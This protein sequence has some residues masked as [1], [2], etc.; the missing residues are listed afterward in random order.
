[1]KVQ[2]ENQ[3]LQPK[4]HHQIIPLKT[5]STQPLLLSLMLCNLLHSTAAAEAALAGTVLAVPAAEGRTALA[6][7]LVLVA[8]ASLGPRRRLLVG[9]GD[10][11]G[12][13]GQVRTQVLDALLGEVAVVV[14][15]REG[16]TDVSLGVERLHEVQNLKVGG[17]LDVGVG[18]R[19]SVL[20]NDTNSL[21]EEVR[22]DS[23][24]VGLRDEHGWSLVW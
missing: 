15:P 1:M 16:D 11:L 17:S 19:D 23:N 5:N 7:E 8:L 10:D 18:G 20:L 3:T 2:L 24:A 9:G 21:T 14:L 12:G 6:A 13:K 22:E 4:L